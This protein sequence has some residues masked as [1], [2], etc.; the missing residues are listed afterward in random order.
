MA[1]RGTD[2]VPLAEISAEAGLIGKQAVQY[3]FGSREGLV[4]AILEYR[5]PQVDQARLQIVETIEPLEQ[6]PLQLL[7]TAMF[8]PTLDQV[9]CNGKC[10]FARL[11]VSLFL[12]K[13]NTS[14]NPWQHSAHTGAAQR[15]YRALRDCCED[16]SDEEFNIKLNLIIAMFFSVVHSFDHDSERKANQTFSQFLAIAE[17]A[18]LM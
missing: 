5:L 6:A 10:S 9:D 11:A 8:R 12:T 3:H 16:L 14:A 1:T 7:L 2:D 13:W 4:A 18:L 15:V 17:R